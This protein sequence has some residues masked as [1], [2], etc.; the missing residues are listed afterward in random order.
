ML[1]CL[2]IAAAAATADDAVRAAVLKSVADRWAPDVPFLCVDVVS[3]PPQRG[4]K[5]WHIKLVG[6][7][8]SAA[9]LGMA[10]TTAPLVF[11]RSACS[12]GA[13]YDGP[14]VLRKTS[15]SGGVTV[16]MGP[17]SFVGAEDARVVVLTWAG[18]LS[19]TFSE[20]KVR[21]KDGAWA[22]VGSTIV[23]QE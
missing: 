7:D 15:Q 23:L 20:W 17:V 21:R 16:S 6:A 3:P 13:D 10:R 1:L 2:L 8:P 19:H 9:T 14:I 11:P 4:T 5:Y 12:I 22:A 18:G